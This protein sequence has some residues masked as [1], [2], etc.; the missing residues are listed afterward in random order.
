[1]V[2]KR[3]DAVG[4]PLGKPL[5]DAAV[6]EFAA[7]FHGDLIRPG[8]DG[9]DSARAV[10]NNMIDRHPALIARCTGVADVAAAVNFAHD[11]EL[12][13]AVRGGG[14]SVPGY[15]VCEGGIVIDLSPMKGIWVDP[16]T[17]TARAQSGVTWG[18]FD[19]ETQQFGLA[20]TGGRVTHTGIAGLTLGSGSG[21]LERK[22]GLTCDN[23]I[24]ADVV[25]AN[26]EFLKASEEENEDLF[27]GLRGGGG[28]FG[29]VTSFEYRLHPLES[30][31]LGGML[32]YPF[33]KAGEL[34]R[35][36]RDYLEGAPDELGGAA[37]FM[38][39]PPAPF[40]P[41]HM[42]GKLAAGLV[43]FYAG[44]PEE[45]EEWVRPLKEFG[46]PEVDLVQPMPYT[47][48]Q[49]LLDPANPPGRN[50]YWKAEHLDELSD[51]AI[52]TIVVHAAKISSPFTLIVILPMGGAISD[53]EE[54]ETAI[55][56]RDAACGVH[57]ISMW[58]NPAESETHIAWAREFMQAMEPFTI[59]GIS[60]NFTSDQTEDKVKASFGS[61]KKYERL[62]ALKNKYDPTNLFRL[63]QNI[64][65]TAQ[66]GAVV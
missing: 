33:S 10:F 3:D 60:L 55:G 18:E 40:V 65:P 66:S 36:W 14:H 56:G 48:V 7:N 24:S 32:L 16:G 28:N 11:N 47:V 42:K 54:D 57:A 31:V 4:V 1:M 12:V 22:Y 9:Y 17:S 44:S 39:A 38:T 63:N 35:F 29:I 25:T 37:A 34:L 2:D 27:W 51:E 61:E 19:R 21:W 62:I 20:T 15:A 49:T 13:V 5:E 59:P 26:G 53:V 41:E 43:V 64:K 8:D 45:G 52:D 23:L 50:N 6:Q 58:E 30:I 46:P